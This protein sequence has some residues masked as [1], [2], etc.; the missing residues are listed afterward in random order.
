MNEKWGNHAMS[1]TVNI[2]ETKHGESVLFE[3]LSKLGI[4]TKTIEHKPMFTVEDSISL[5]G[6]LPGGHC[7]SLFLKNKK[8]QYWLVVMLENKRLDIK[9]LGNLLKS[10][11]LSFCS[12]ERLWHYLGVLP[13]SVT[14]FSIINDSNN[15]VSVILDKNM[16]ALSPL[17]YHPLQNH[18]TTAIS[19]LDLLLFLRS[20]GYEPNI[21]D[22]NFE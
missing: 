4:D 12:P 10:G 6:N 20:E 9:A 11:R 1:K 13:G 16:M 22:L 5:R 14:P 21:I 3:R 8:N 2:E 19:N 17:H 18:K 7:K 15:E